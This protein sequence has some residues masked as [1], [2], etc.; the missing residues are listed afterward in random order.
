VDQTFL[1]KKVKEKFFDGST[2]EFENLEVFEVRFP[3]SDT[4]KMLFYQVWDER[5]PI[6]NS[7]P[8]KTF[9]LHTTQFEEIW[10]KL[11][12]VSGHENKWAP[13]VEMTVSDISNINYYASVTRVAIDNQDFVIYIKQGHFITGQSVNILREFNNVS[14]FVNLSKIPCNFLL[15]G[16]KQDLKNWLDCSYDKMSNDNELKKSNL[17][18]FGN[19]QLNYNYQGTVTIKS[20]KNNNNLITFGNNPNTILWY[21]VWDEADHFSND[22]QNGQFLYQSTLATFYNHVKKYNDQ[23]SSKNLNM[24]EYG[25]KPSVVLSLLDVNNGRKDFLCVIEEFQTNPDSDTESFGMVVSTQKFQGYPNLGYPKIPSGTFYV[26]MNIDS[27]SSNLDLF[28]IIYPENL[29]RDPIPGNNNPDNPFRAYLDYTLRI[30][31]KLDSDTEIPIWMAN[32][33]LSLK[34]NNLIGAT[35]TPV[36]P[37]LTPGSNFIDYPVQLG[38]LPSGSISNFNTENTYEPIIGSRTFYGNNTN[39]I[40]EPENGKYDLYV[41]FP[42]YSVYKGL[43][44]T[45][46]FNIAATVPK[47]YE[48]LK[49]KGFTDKQILGNWPPPKKPEPEE[50]KQPNCV[51]S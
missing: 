11:P 24:N 32:I 21:S 37:S 35:D 29:T 12:E 31:M 49:S 48:L 47:V 28:F 16:L 39:F 26:N 34:L 46:G 44:N 15:P 6:S 51:I 43:T 4:E 22:A 13:V 40:G 27:L 19:K 5:T 3:L 14:V 45:S 25:F 18:T 23:V 30:Q 42:F 2:L 10:N 8:F 33:V 50:T 38:E 1:S 17:S 7:K 36:N 41:N 9:L 20:Y